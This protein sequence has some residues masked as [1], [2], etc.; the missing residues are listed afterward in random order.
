MV[1]VGRLAAIKHQATTIQAVA[2]TAG[3][4]ALIGGRQA[5]NAP[6]Y[7]A[8]LKERA[9]QVGMNER[10]R[11]TGDLAGGGCARLVSAGDG[12][13]QHESSRAV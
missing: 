13:G 12:R 6:G 8:M 9:A 3:E 10:C 2:G 11:F 4:L 7:E 5:G 1:Q